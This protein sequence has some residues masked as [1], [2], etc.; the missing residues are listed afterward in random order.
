[1]IL[2]GVM[3]RPQDFGHLKRLRTPAKVVAGLQIQRALINKIVNS[4]VTAIRL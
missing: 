4:R 2:T 1:M 3:V